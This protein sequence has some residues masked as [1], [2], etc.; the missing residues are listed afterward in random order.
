M[1][2]DQIDVARAKEAIAALESPNSFARGDATISQ[3]SG[4]NP[5]LLEH[6]VSGL[7]QSQSENAQIKLALAISKYGDKAQQF[8]EPLIDL[9]LPTLS[10][11]D[12]VAGAII[13]TIS[14]IHCEQSLTAFKALLQSTNPQLQAHALNNLSNLGEL[15]NRLIPDLKA[16][17]DRDPDVAP[18]V[19]LCLKDF[20]Q[21]TRTFGS[22]AIDEEQPPL[23]DLS[24]DKYEH[25]EE[26]T[27]NTDSKGLLYDQQFRFKISSGVG[28]CRLR[29]GKTIDGTVGVFLSSDRHSFGPSVTNSFEL[30]AN[31]LRKIFP[32]LTDETLWFEHSCPS[33]GSGTCNSLMKVLMNTNDIGL[34]TNVET[35]WQQ[36]RHPSD[37]AQRFGINFDY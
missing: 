3:I 1:Q 14:K 12:C 20:Y 11:S 24:A 7:Q 36:T 9:I 13:F 4:K 37:I 17:K 26:K 35:S 2:R 19:D 18:F 10:I 31:G 25:L 23:I 28:Q 22:V 32:Q 29:I 27:F 15:V 6:L 33:N 5:S 30:L 21:A 34:F 16:L 8:V